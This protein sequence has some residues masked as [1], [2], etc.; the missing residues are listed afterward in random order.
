MNISKDLIEFKGSVSKE[1]A[2]KMATNVKLLF[3]S[4]IAISVTGNAG[5]RRGDLKKK[6]GTIFIGIA[7]SSGVE[8][9]KFYFSGNRNNIVNN[10]VKQSF[11]LIYKELIK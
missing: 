2:S 5:P 10:A 3:N 6:I 8:V 1:I 7:K 9:Y 4:N 11:N